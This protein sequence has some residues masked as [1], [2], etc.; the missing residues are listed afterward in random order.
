MVETSGLSPRPTL[1]P[2]D[3]TARPGGDEQRPSQRSEP[4]AAPKV[5]ETR[6]SRPRPAD[7]PSDEIQRVSEFIPDGVDQRPDGVDQ[8]L[9]SQ[10]TESLV[11]RV[12]G[13]AEFQ[14]AAAGVGR[15]AALVQTVEQASDAVSTQLKRIAA[16]IKEAADPKVD[17]RQRGSL[18]ERISKARHEINDISRNA[19]FA[20]VNVLDNRGEPGGKVTRQARPEHA[21]APAPE[22]KSEARPPKPVE[23]RPP[24][25]RTSSLST[26]DL[27]I[28][29]IDIDN[30]D[31]LRD[32]AD[33]V[34]KASER[35]DKGRARLSE[36][37]SEL[38]NNVSALKDSIGSRLSDSA[39]AR[40]R[41]EEVAEVIR[42]QPSSAALA[43]RNA[44][45]VGVLNLLV[46]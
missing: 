31:N 21:P 27:D 29:D 34:K 5:D 18:H 39:S 13:F 8:R 2:M 17:N 10:V 14:H 1:P 38:A 4:A 37:R 40:R 30:D 6:E 9:E 32:A 36:A 22:S 26:A 35:V 15:A 24:P 43:T 16:A 28:D 23:D 45:P 12:R 7:A 11:N 19:Q 44:S 20:G 46:G 3:P 41:V 25:R 42:S 33:R